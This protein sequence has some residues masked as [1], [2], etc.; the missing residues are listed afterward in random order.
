VPPVKLTRLGIKHMPPQLIVEY[1]VGPKRSLHYVQLSAEALLA[2]IEQLI[3]ELKVD[4]MHRPYLCSVPTTQLGELLRRLQQASS[5][6]KRPIKDSW[7]QENPMRRKALGSRGRSSPP[8]MSRK[9]QQQLSTPSVASSTAHEK[10]VGR[11]PPQAQQDG[12]SISDRTNCMQHGQS[13]PM[14]AW[15]QWSLKANEGSSNNTCSR[16]SAVAGS[17][18]GNASGVSDSSNSSGTFSN[19]NSS[20]N[21]S[22]EIFR[23]SRGVRSIVTAFKGLF[24]TCVAADPGSG[25]QNG[26]PLDIIKRVV[27]QQRRL[28]R[29]LWDRLRL[30]QAQG[31]GP[32]LG[33][34]VVVVGAG[35]VGLRCAL[36]LRTL[37]A[38]VV[39][40]ERR[41]DFD[42]IN[43]LHLWPWCG[44]D[45]KSWGAKVLEPPEMSFGSDP[46]FLHIGIAELQ[47]LLF[48]AC[49]LLGVQVFFGTEFVASQPTTQCGTP[50][51][52]VHC[53]LANS[54]HPGPTAPSVLP[55]VSILIGADGTHGSVARA[56]CLQLV[57]A[58]NLRKE[59]ALGLVANYSNRQTHAEKNMRPFS[60]ARQ[61]FETLFKKC[62]QQTGVELENIV[63]Y[64]SAQTH[65]LV[66]TPTK[67]SLQNLGAWPIGTA[68]GSSTSEKVQSDAAL[69]Q[70]ARSVAAFPWKP[71]QEPLPQEVLDSPVGAPSLFD[72]SRTRRAASGLHVVQTDTGQDEKPAQLLI[73]L[74]GDALI[75]PFW[76][77]GLGIIRGFF[78]ALDIASATK[79]WVQTGSRD[80][81]TSH[82]EAA[83]RQ[84]KT[85]SASTRK[86]VL[87][88]D[89]RAYGLDPAS[90]YRFASQAQDR[91]S[92]M[93]AIRVRR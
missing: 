64:S 28:A 12:P 71:G 37:G 34:C 52:E 60:L 16:S 51:W 70:I 19:G 82:F 15:A 62:E 69:A 91:S 40:L 80:E 23:K 68:T 18:V 33:K 45:L 29:E 36:E 83:Y 13:W 77:E 20:I 86:T 57:E 47:M 49:L 90:R 6:D 3:D 8:C 67:K 65:Y 75:E 10:G 25:E 66:M 81:A 21:E 31:D 78:G 30:H 93:P 61:F 59:A 41:T 53:H 79:V 5:Q 46:D 84:L 17:G 32:L 55:G 7:S 74:C 1:C 11:R 56:H 72:F 73:G 4:P 38:N 88:P 54:N 48:K 42:R 92:S 26:D 22:F 27:G 85:L 35:P 44:E 24:S 2:N 87:R 76:P 58:G 39:V 89:E 14:H 50:S 9:R 63:C 43:R